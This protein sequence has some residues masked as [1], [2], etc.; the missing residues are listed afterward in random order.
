M[1]QIPLV[2]ETVFVSACVTHICFILFP[3]SVPH[4]AEPI[5]YQSVRALA[6]GALLHEVI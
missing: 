5:P 3:V 1:F 2:D 4:Q 6:P